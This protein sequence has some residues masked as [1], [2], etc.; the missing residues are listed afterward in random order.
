MATESTDNP[1]P[2]LKRKPRKCPKC[3][4][5]P[6]GSILWGLPVFSDELEQKMRE[7]RIV[8][9]GCCVDPE[10]DPS[11]QCSQCGWQG[12]MSKPVRQDPPKR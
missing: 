3:G 8:L 12:W 1:N 2:T 11:W 5:H 6:V 9:G 4:H 10:N 7:G